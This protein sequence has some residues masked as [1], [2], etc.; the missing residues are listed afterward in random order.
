MT[1][2]VAPTPSKVATQRKKSSAGGPSLGSRRGNTIA[3]IA[4]WAIGILFVFPV[5]FMVLTSTPRS[6]HQPTH[7][8]SSPRSP[9]R[10]TRS[11]SVQPREP[12]HGPR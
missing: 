6:T 2:A 11:S 10:V 3:G 12:A 5:F 7:P 4:A 9:S 8:A 1:T